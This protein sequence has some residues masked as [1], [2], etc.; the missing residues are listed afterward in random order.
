MASQD[1]HN[2]EHRSVQLQPI[3]SLLAAH[4]HFGTAMYV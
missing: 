2:Y 4:P 3:P 1:K